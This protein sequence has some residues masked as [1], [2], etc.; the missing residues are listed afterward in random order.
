MNDIIKRIETM[1]QQELQEVMRA[2]ER[3]YADAFPEW[4]VVYV[5]T[6]KDPQLRVQE[7]EQI[8]QLI[9]KGKHG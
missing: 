5:A 9:G 6:H 3:R 7:Y 8:L 4:E 2:I 1:T